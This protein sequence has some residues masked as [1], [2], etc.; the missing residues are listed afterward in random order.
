MS[1]GNLFEKSGRVLD[2]DQSFESLYTRLS[3]KKRMKRMNKNIYIH[4]NNN[5]INQ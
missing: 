5:N 1:I 2:P 4:K 3:S